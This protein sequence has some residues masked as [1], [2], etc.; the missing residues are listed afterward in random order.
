MQ[1]RDR[2]DIIGACSLK[3]MQQTRVAVEVAVVIAR[4]KLIIVSI[5]IFCTECHVY[6]PYSLNFLRENIF[7]DFDVF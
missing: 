7:A 4:M 6:I 5:I 2:I 1:S 3:R